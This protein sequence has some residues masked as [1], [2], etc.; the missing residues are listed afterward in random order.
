MIVVWHGG[1]DYH[2]KPTPHTIK[3]LKIWDYLEKL[4][5]AR[6]VFSCVPDVD[7]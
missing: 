5:P 2:L 1:D 4:L 7:G 3:D 6:R